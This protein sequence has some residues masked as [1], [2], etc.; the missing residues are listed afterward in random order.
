MA[1][2]IEIMARAIHDEIERLETD[3]FDDDCVEWERTTEGKRRERIHYALAALSAL[4]KAGYAVVPVKPT[5]AMFA[6]AFEALVPAMDAQA[7]YSAMIQAAQVP[8]DEA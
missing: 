1:D 6:A 3:W 7:C 2:P 5:E 4:K 8:H